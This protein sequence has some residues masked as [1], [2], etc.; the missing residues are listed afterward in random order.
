MLVIHR[1]LFTAYVGGWA[2]KTVIQDFCEC[3]GRANWH[4]VTELKY[5]LVNDILQT[6]L[7]KKTNY[8]TFRI[9][10]VCGAETYCLNYSSFSYH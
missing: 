8:F 6:V 1:H 7:K 10:Y 3:M 5:L 2:C 4:S 9:G